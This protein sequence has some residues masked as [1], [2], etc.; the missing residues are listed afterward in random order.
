MHYEMDGLGWIAGE[1]IVL[2]ALGGALVA[3]MWGII[4]A[5]YTDITKQ[6]E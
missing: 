6:T 1:L 4:L 3:E 2:K 5:S